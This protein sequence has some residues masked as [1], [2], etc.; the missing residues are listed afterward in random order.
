MRSSPV[1][2]PK[3]VSNNSGQIVHAGTQI[4]T[5]FAQVKDGNLEPSQP[6]QITISVFSKEEF[7]RAY[8]MLCEARQKYIDSLSNDSVISDS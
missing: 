7:E 3:K 5:V 1:N 8:N 6:L 2:A 4:Q